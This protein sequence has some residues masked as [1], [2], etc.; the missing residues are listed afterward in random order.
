MP[1]TTNNMGVF[2]ASAHTSEANRLQAV[3]NHKGAEQKHLEA[4]G[5]K[6][7][8]AGEDSVP[9]ALTKNALGELYLTMGELDKAQTML[10][11]A[12]VIRSS[13]PSSDS[14]SK[15]DEVC[16][17]DNLGRLWEMRGDFAKAA[18]LRTK[19]SEKMMCSN[20]NVSSSFSVDES[21]LHCLEAERAQQ[22][23]KMSLCLVLWQGLPERG[24]EETQGILQGCMNA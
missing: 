4:L 20:F 14:A 23:R 1:G 6:I 22:V 21:P 12:D 18:E 16:T 13:N 5:M 3:G 19:D 9:V 17:K 15:F 10:E 24:L 2:Q 8:A 7:S 11:A